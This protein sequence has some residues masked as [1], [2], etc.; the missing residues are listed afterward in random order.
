MSGDVV[1]LQA[2]HY[3]KSNP[4]VTCT[5]LYH[6]HPKNDSWHSAI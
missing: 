4:T 3:P 1:S 2:S 6:C 5:V